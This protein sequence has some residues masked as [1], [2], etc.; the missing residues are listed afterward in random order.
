MRLL[1]SALVL[2]ML[3]LTA[4]ADPYKLSVY[5]EGPLPVAREIERAFE[6]YRGDVLSILPL[7]PDAGPEPDGALGTADIVWGGGERLLG[8]LVSGQR[9]RPYSSTE[10]GALVKGSAVTRGAVSGLECTVIVYDPARLSGSAVPSR[11]RDLLDPRFRGRLAIKSPSSGPDSFAVAF[12][13]VRALDWPFLESLAAQRPLTTATHED[14]L[15]R[16]ASGDALAAIVPYHAVTAA[17]QSLAVVWPADARIAAPRPIVILEQ[18][19]RPRMMTEL[20]EQLVDYI[21]SADGQAIGKRYG[22][23]STRLDVGPPPGA[24]A[25][26]TADDAEPFP[27]E[28]PGAE[29]RDRVRRLFPAR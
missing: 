24:P 27:S 19:K 16:L 11:W 6:A 20:A 12:A 18:A 5:Y 7:S 14:A 8:Q 2:A 9:V 3:A 22:L 13:M 25:A 26:Q 28:P 1:G 15:A 23:Y 29:F 10:F 21:L 4:Q 17:R